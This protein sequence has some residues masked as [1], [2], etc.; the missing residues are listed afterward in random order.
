M[1]KNT[2]KKLS[3]AIL[4]KQKEVEKIVKEIEKASSVCLI[5]LKNLPDR[6]LQK[7][8]K[9]LKGQIK[10]IV[11]KKAVITR[12]LEKTKK[13]FKSKI[14]FPA[15]L[16]LSDT[17]SPYKLYH[18]FKAN[19]QKVFAKP[20]QIA[21]EDIEIKAGETDLSAG[22]ALTELKNAKIPAIIK[23]G[24]IAIQKDVVVVKKGEIIN[25]QIAK[26]L[27]KLNIAPFEVF[28][29]I[30]EGISQEI[31]YT[32]EIFDLEPN[33]IKDELAYSYHIA[34]NLA[35]N[36]NYPS[37]VVIEQLIKISYNQAKAVATNSMVYSPTSITEVL[38]NAT[39]Q[40]NALEKKLNAK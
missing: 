21:E 14:D 24:K 10:I 6:I 12:A 36:S 37:K 28:I 26:A 8:R 7:A 35:M 9:E 39:K 18:I 38:A 11:A 1:N 3:K 20:G 15:A 16:V 5:N 27:Q 31:N 17:V 32:Q 25:E 23:G 34:L 4:K 22:P 2:T 13:K 19:A 40:A 33:K 30:K 29:K